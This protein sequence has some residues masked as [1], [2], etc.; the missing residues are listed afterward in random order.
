MNIYK[1]SRE[2]HRIGFSIK[3]H[4]PEIMM[5]L[6]IVGVISSTVL[7]CKETLEAE[8]EI[9]N[10]SDELERVH[11]S[12]GI[13]M[14]ENRVHSVYSEDDAKNDTI[15]I[16]A[17][18]SIEMVKIYWPSILMTA[19]SITCF[20]AANGVLKKR[21]A[22]LAAT[23]TSINNSF[24][25]YRENIRSKYGEDADKEAHF[26]IK[27]EYVEQPVGDE[28]TNQVTSEKVIS[29]NLDHSDYAKFF[30]EAC[31]GWTKDPEEN[32]RFL[33]QKQKEANDILKKKGYLYLNQVYRMLDIPET[34][35][36]SIVGWI[37]NEDSDV[38]DNYVDFGIYN[39]ADE[40]HVAFVN[41]YERT[42]I[43]D[44][45]VDGPITNMDIGLD[46]YRTGRPRDVYDYPYLNN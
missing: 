24:K 15:K 46:D 14:I 22:V 23:C 35:A 36:G 4:S 32:L 42:I 39:G 20:L 1:I 38:S 45:N 30:S 44:F 2:F 9:S 31:E 17:K 7:A 13:P 43:L 6:G 34:E 29:Y 3:A 10:A 18:L 19:S 41:G 11:K 33:K 25:K 16:Y 28:P 26:G 8:D 21:N 12:I 5:S 27:Q 40:R 37:Y